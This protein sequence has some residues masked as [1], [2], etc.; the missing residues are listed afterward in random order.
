M[1]G[2]PVEFADTGSKVMKFSK[3][4]YGLGIKDWHFGR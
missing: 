4:I 2:N 1:I 3:E